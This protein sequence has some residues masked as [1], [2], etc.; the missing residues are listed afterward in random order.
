MQL[1][2]MIP[3]DVLEELDKNPILCVEMHT[4]G[5]P[6]RIIYANYPH[7]H[8]TLLEQRAQARRDHDSI[9][10]SILL[11]PRG[12]NDMYGAILCR[13]TELVDR[14]DAHM[15]VLFMTTE[16]YSTMCGHATIALGRFLVDIH[17]KNIFPHRDELR[18]DPET[19]TTKLLLHAPCGLLEVTAP[20]SPGGHKADA[21][22]NVSF[23]SV[24]S[25]APG[26]GVQI[27]VPA[28]L[29]WPQLGSRTYVTGDISYGGAFFIIISTLR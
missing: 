9:R 25:F 7:L 11:E 13:S 20:T 14:G 16:G 26:L 6:T 4:T 5:E 23:L 2:T 17:D 12:H 18:Y 27:A 24:P 15:G 3:T 28:D 10:K 29:R 1:R 19:Q 22:R 21:S 8:G